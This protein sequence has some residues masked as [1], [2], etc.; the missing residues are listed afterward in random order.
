MV[1]S[2]A[3]ERY[4]QRPKDKVVPAE[5]VV[6]KQI[7]PLRAAHLGISRGCSPGGRHSAGR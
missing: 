5:A 1:T 3:A 6:R 2:H 4:A 7:L